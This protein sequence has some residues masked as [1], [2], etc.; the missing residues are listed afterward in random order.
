[1]TTK[2]CEYCDRYKRAGHNYCRM[3]GHNLTRGYVQNVRVAEAYNT[4]ERFC[5]HCGKAKHTGDCN[6]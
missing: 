5:G 2:D 3:C 6:V 1:M 4:A